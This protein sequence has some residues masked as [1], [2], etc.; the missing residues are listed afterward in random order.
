MDD[1]PRSKMSVVMK[2][3]L[4]FI[5]RIYSSISGMNPNVYMPYI[6]SNVMTMLSML[7]TC[8]SKPGTK[9]QWLLTVPVTWIN[10]GSGNGLSP[11]RHQAITDNNTDLLPIGH[12][13]NFQ[14]NLT[15]NIKKVY[16]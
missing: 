12:F 15:Q 16:P 7:S 8:T 10:I 9:Q 6:V 1:F 2:S 11:A 14:Q 3:H 13:K 4:F 5:F